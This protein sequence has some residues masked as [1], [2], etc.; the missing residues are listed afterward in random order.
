MY[1]VACPATVVCLI[2]RFFVR[3]DFTCTFGRKPLK[4]IRF[5][6]ERVSYSGLLC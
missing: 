3:L 5:Y 2:G 6:R 4:S 1:G